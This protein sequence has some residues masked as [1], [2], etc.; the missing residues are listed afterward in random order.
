MSDTSTGKI[1]IEAPLSKVEGILFDLALYPTWS[2]AIKSVAVLEKDEKGRATSAT[3]T[4]DAGMMKD[5]VTLA[6][7]WSQAPKRLSFT[8]TDADL[9]TEMDGAYIIT[10]QDEDST[11]VTY[12]LHVDLSMP[13]P[14]MMI[15]KAEKATID[16]ALE[17]LKT[18]AEK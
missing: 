3:M 12:E 11:E 15:H 5:R 14:A 16:M 2:S 13:I 18:Y 4:I 6:Y 10:A 17:Q 8:M 1:S 7:D 9:L